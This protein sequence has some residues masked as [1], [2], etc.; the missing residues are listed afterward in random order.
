MKLCQENS[1][2]AEKLKS[3]IDQYELREEVRAMPRLPQGKAESIASLSSPRAV[4]RVSGG[5]NKSSEWDCARSKLAG[6]C[7]ANSL[8]KELWR[9]S[10][11]PAAPLAAWLLWGEGP[12]HP[13]SK[14]R[15]LPDKMPNPGPLTAP[16]KP[17]GPPSAPLSCSH[18]PQVPTEH[19][20]A[21]IFL[22]RLLYW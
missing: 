14:V 21:P 18:L 7:L 16:P 22:D 2:L 3:I 4:V 17:R 10:T 9:T 15:Q 12:R 8:G 1:E 13:S 5:G 19:L 11:L 6:F 20:P